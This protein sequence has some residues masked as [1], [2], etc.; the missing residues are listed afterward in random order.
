MAANHAE[1][2]KDVTG[3]KTQ[4]FASIRT[5]QLL[6]SWLI[7]ALTPPATMV[8]SVVLMVVPLL[9]ACF[10]LLVS[11]FW[12]VVLMLSTDTRLVNPTL[13]TL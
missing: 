7:H 11:L 1:H 10:W 8:A 9:V 5:N 13:T 2:T 12:G 3:V 6:A 4:R